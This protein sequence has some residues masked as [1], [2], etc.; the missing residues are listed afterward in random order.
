VSKGKK[1][2]LSGFTLAMG[3]IKAIRDVR[4]AYKV[5][6]SKKIN[7][8]IYA[9]NSKKLIESQ[10]VLI[11]NLR[12][13]VKDLEV[14]TKGDRID[15]A[16]FKSVADVKMYLLVRDFD[17]KAERERIIKEIAEKKKIIKA[18]E[19]KLK[20]KDFIK[21]AP[22][23]IVE[24]EQAKLNLRQGELKKLQEQLKNIK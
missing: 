1:V 8:V 21:K 20:N 5:N 4:S 13:G 11:K 10:S 15:N 18:Q 24:Q 3:I 16:I 9:G 12:T 19:S 7:V 23:E 22:G 6:P 14:K 17:F 2:S